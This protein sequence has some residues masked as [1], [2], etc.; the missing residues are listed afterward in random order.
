[1]KLTPINRKRV[2]YTARK[3]IQEHFG[4][5]VKINIFMIIWQIL[6]VWSGWGVV[7]LAAVLATT[8]TPD[9]LSSDQGSGNYI[10]SFIVQTILAVLVW[11]TM[12]AIIDQFRKP[13][14]ASSLG[15]ILQAFSGRRFLPTF[16]LA[17]DQRILI[18]LW[19]LCFLVPGFVKRFSYAQTYYALKMDQL[20]HRRQ[21]SLTDYITISRRVMYGRKFE[22]FCLE[23]S[24]I[25]WH[26]LGIFTLGFAYIYI[27]PYLNTSRVVYSSQIFTLATIE[28]AH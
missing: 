3:H 7:A 26:L 1:M 16:V 22:L 11:S 17:L 21:G 10:G 19:H 24:F 14:E 28:G 23:L 20:Y 9:T 8:T 25:G 18:F 15:N 6:R 12:W 2:K 4:Q 5:A 13:K 27:V